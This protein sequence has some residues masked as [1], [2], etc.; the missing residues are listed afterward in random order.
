MV[1]ETPYIVAEP[2]NPAA[3]GKGQI[4]ELYKTTNGDICYP[5]TVSDAVATY[6]NRKCW[7]RWK[8]LTNAMNI[9]SLDYGTILLSGINLNIFDSEWV[10]C[11]GQTGTVEY[12]GSS[13][14]FNIP[15]INLGFMHVPGDTVISGDPVIPTTSTTTKKLTTTTSAHSISTTSTPSIST[16]STPSISTT[17]TPSIST[18]STTPPSKKVILRFFTDERGEIRDNT[19]V[20]T[21]YGEIFSLPYVY[22]KNNYKE[23]AY[24]F[25]GFGY[26][27]SDEV[28]YSPNYR[29]KC[30]EQQDID[31]YA[32]YEEKLEPAPDA[33]SIYIVVLNNIG[34]TILALAQM[35]VD[36]YERNRFAWIT[37]VDSSGVAHVNGSF[38]ISSMAGP[39]I[40]ENGIY[41]MYSDIFGPP[42][43]Y[44]I[45]NNYHNLI[46]YNGDF[47]YVSEYHNILIK[48]E[49]SSVREGNIQWSEVTTY[50]D[51]S[52]SIN[53]STIF[54]TGNMYFAEG[55]ALVE[56]V[57]QGS[58]KDEISKIMFYSS[59]DLI[60]WNKTE[61]PYRINYCSIKDEYG[62]YNISPTIIKNY[63]NV[64]ISGDYYDRRT[65]DGPTVIETWNGY[66]YFCIKR[67][68]YTENNPPVEEYVL[69]RTNN[70]TTI[71]DVYVFSNDVILDSHRYD[72]GLSSTQNY[73]YAGINGRLYRFDTTFNMVICKDI[74]NDDIIQ[75]KM[76]DDM[77]YVYGDPDRVIA[78]GET[79]ASNK[80]SIAK[81]SYMT[82]RQSEHI[83][84]A[85]NSTTKSY[86]ILFKTNF[87][88]GVTE[89]A[90]N[91]ILI[92]NELYYIKDIEN[93]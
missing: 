8:T 14:T 26:Y 53:Y 19:T 55:K 30:N 13:F 72:S 75:Y 63:E 54:K 74:D 67:N 20:E 82:L 52:N 58:Y 1:Q 56:Y 6:I 60:H 92:D 22:V 4:Y 61:I 16:T 24:S 31:L 71:E 84:R 69:C 90:L 27:D 76:F 80:F 64:L 17:S 91:G 81:N 49:G 73:L 86:T 29:N 70:F 33:R 77:I 79:K 51:D 12:N 25:L 23:S 42:N 15:Y 47:Y 44:R 59:S 10:R 9:D 89:S 7:P 18:T 45:G 34:K 11:S 2:N 41:D 93:D 5:I 87:I 66:Y 36:K 50:V 35:G 65:T 62:I 3:N 28:I 78:P 38:Y 37:N 88:S 57:E 83:A 21:E 39:F 46:E 32:I 68:I 43:Q 48:I 85:Y 40:S